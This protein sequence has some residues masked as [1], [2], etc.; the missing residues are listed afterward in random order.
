MTV[1]REQI[2]ET[3]ARAI[4]PIYWGDVPS[5]DDEHPPKAAEWE[6][7]HE[8]TRNQMRAYANAALDAAIPLLMQAIRDDRRP[9]SADGLF[10]REIA[11]CVLEEMLSAEQTS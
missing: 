1:T 8:Y 3:M 11:C 6:A 7:Q 9:L 4:F 2:V 10:G 5:F